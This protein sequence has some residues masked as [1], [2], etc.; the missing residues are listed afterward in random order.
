MFNLYRNE[1]VK[2]LY[3]TE[4]FI[5]LYSSSNALPIEKIP[6][7]LNRSKSSDRCH[8]AKRKCTKEFFLLPRKK[9][10]DTLSVESNNSGS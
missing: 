10:R 1:S 7:V 5:N 2:K 8:N 6:I 3:N 9:T 4:T